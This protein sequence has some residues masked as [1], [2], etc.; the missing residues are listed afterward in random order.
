MGK[1]VIE[2][3]GIPVGI[4]IPEAGM[5]RF[6]AVKLHVIDLDGR[7]YASTG[8]VVASIHQLMAGAG[9]KAPSSLAA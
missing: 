3:A 7:I 8:D 2:Y 5:L 4:V 1:Q 9:G 6:L